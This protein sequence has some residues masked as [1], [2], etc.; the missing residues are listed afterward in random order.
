MREEKLEK[1]AEQETLRDSWTSLFPPRD[2]RTE[3][4]TAFRLRDCI[5]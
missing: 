2:R 1:R 5:G 3:L 4:G